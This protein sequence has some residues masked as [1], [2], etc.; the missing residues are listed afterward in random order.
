M[1]SRISGRIVTYALDEETDET[2]AAEARDVYEDVLEVAAEEVGFE[3]QTLPAYS[4]QL[5]FDDPRFEY[6]YSDDVK[7]LFRDPM[8]QALEE[9]EITELL[10]DVTGRALYMAACIA[11]EDI[12]IDDLTR[13]RLLEYR[14]GFGFGFPQVRLSQTYFQSFTPD[15]LKQRFNW[16]PAVEPEVADSASA[17][18]GK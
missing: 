15:A 16:Q 8:A 6:R 18:A 13:R 14:Y 7:Y 17:A 11:E 5:S 9:G 10:D 4:R 3:I 1:P 2:I 12:T